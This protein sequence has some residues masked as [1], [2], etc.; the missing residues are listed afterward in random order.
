M[1]RFFRYVVAYTFALASALL[2]SLYGVMSATGFFALSKAIILGLVAFGGSHGP[3]YAATLRQSYGPQGARLATFAAGLCLIVTLW[4]GL[5]T[6]A[7]GGA[8]MQA[9]RR[10]AA[11]DA[12]RDR[13]TLAR[14]QAER[15]GLPAHRPAA[16]VSAD[17]TTARASPL[18]KS[19]E[20]C[21]PE[22]IAGPKSRD[23]CRQYRQLEGE[24]ATAHEAAR[25]DAGI[26][27]VSKR[28][29]TAPPEIEADPQAS[30]FSRLTGLSVEFSAAL[31]ALFASLALEAT[32]MVAMMVAWAEPQLAQQGATKPVP[33][34]LE[35]QP[36][37]VPRPKP[38]T[39]KPQTSKPTNVVPIPK[40][41][42]SI[43]KW[44]AARVATV[45]GERLE[46]R[47]LLN[48]YQQWCQEGSLP[49]APLERF[50]DEI[51]GLFEVRPD[52]DNK[53]YALNVG[54][55]A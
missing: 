29:A 48:S 20:G 25:I 12:A 30:A 4:G 10:K 11:G 17:L 33:A 49:A 28:L 21:E 9:E 27:D 18:Y 39:A 45:P 54:L 46:I 22:K 2:A 24:L 3:A 8:E 6:M 50:L 53:V 1:K 5:G 16:A 13:A 38:A 37:P 47:A 42:G 23:H 43:K 31:Y 15:D 41:F 35:R 51:D 52:G 36:A 7:G 19:T 44:A 34:A 26:A 40:V 32:A 14:L 55:A